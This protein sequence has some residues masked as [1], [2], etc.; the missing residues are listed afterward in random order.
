MSDSRAPLSLPLRHEERPSKTWAL[1][2][3]SVLLPLTAC[4]LVPFAMVAF[5]GPDLIK[6]AFENPVGMAELSLGAVVWIG[7][8]VAPVA[9]FARRNGIAR[10]VIV[11]ARE[12]TVTEASALGSDTRTEPLA[13][14]DG[15]VHVVRTSVSGMRHE[16]CLVSFAHRRRTVIYTAERIGRETIDEMSLLLGLPEIAARDA[17]N[18]GGVRARPAAAAADFASATPAMQPVTANPALA[19]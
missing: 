19:A 11:T 8:F 14:Y 4:M 15:L 18:V 1:M 9:I 2:L 17:L 6:L 10:Q 16:L 3:V 7:L 13:S 5:A 12:V